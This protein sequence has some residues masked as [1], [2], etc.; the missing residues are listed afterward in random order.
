VVRW[1]N[2][3]ATAGAVLQQQNAA[4]AEDER[5]DEDDAESAEDAGEEEGAD[6]EPTAAEL[7]AEAREL[8]QWPELSAQ[9]RAFTSTT[10]GLRACTPSLPLGETPEAG[11]CSLIPF[12]AP[13]PCQLST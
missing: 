7:D 3:D 9:V 1:S 8:L 10:L 13:P 12:T 4:D 5:E 11:P 2:N 6:G